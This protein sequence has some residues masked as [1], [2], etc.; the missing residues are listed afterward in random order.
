MSDAAWQDA[1]AKYQQIPQYRLEN[2]AMALDGFK[3]IFWWEFA[4]RL[5]GRAI[6]VVVL[7]AFVL[8]R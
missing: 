5:L 1:F 6:G 4:H 8:L 2:A 7:L 3:A